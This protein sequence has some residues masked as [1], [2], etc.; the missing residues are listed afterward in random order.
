MQSKPH[1]STQFSLTDNDIDAL[2]SVLLERETP[3]P[4]TELARLVV[5]RRLET[6]AQAFAD[7][8]ADVAAYAPTQTYKKGQSVV[9]TGDEIIVAKVTAVEDGI[10]PAGF[11]GRDYGSFKRMSVEH[12]GVAEVYAVGLAEGIVEAE[13]EANVVAPSE[14]T[15]TLDEIMQANGRE[16]VRAVDDALRASDTLVRLAGKWFPRELIID[17]NVGHLNLAEAVLDMMEG[18]PLRTPDILEQI[19]GLGD[20]P[21]ELQEFSLNYAMNEDDRFD[22]VGP[23]GEVLWYLHRAAPP[24]VREKPAMLRYTEIDFDEDLLTDEMSDLEEEIDDELSLFEEEEVDEAVVRLIYPHRRVGTLPLN[25][26]TRSIFPTARRAPR[27]YISLLDAQDNT[28]YTGWVLPREGYVYGLKEIYAKHKLPLGTLIKV[29]RGED[30]GQIVIDVPTH[31]P[32]VEY[33]PLMSVKDNQPVFDLQTRQIGV[34]FDE[35]MIIGIDELAPVDALAHTLSQQK[36][37]LTSILKLVVPA[38]SKLSPQGAAHAKTI[39]S[40]VNI[41]RRAPTG[42]I[43]ATLEASP[44]FDNV[45]G[46][47]W[48]LRDN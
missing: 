32:R 22:E 25:S 11:L 30:P 5:E 10:N 23:A 27:V 43:L 8:F 47:Y 16:I 42:L 31:R 26:R 9:L 4:V 29:R 44:D 19:G 36:K 37:N 1:W 14:E 33:I 2:V 34:S 18:G 35:Q 3:L 48:K 17:V 21:A 24:E 28:E 12:D 6:E 45:A 15:L 41:L 39:Y 40:V 20:A 13:A 38:L 7:R 46:H